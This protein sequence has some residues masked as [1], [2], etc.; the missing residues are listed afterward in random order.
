VLVHINYLG[1]FGFLATS[2]LAKR[3]PTALRGNTAWLDMISGPAMGQ[4]QYQKNFG[5]RSGAT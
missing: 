3:K 4:G 5:G 2:D 1:V